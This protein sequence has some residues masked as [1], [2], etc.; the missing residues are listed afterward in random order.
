MAVLQTR[1]AATRWQGFNDLVRGQMQVPKLVALIGR[2]A[3]TVE[4]GLYSDCRVMWIAGGFRVS[5]CRVQVYAQAD[6]G[7]RRVFYTGLPQVTQ[8]G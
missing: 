6:R 8:E 5:F 2:P 7:Q 1:G 4:D 3:G